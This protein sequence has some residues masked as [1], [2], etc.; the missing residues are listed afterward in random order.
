MWSEIFG[1][2]TGSS[3]CERNILTVEQLQSSHKESASCSCQF[4]LHWKLSS[5]L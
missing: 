1:L 3:Y 4:M 2:T 5:I